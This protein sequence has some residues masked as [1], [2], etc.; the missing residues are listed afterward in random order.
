[1]VFWRSICI[2]FAIICVQVTG[3]VALPQQA[4]AQ[5]HVQP[6]AR[7]LLGVYS[8]KD[9]ASLRDSLIHS[10][11]EMPA[12]HLGFHFRYTDVD[13]SLPALDADVRG[14]VVWLT[15]G[16]TVQDPIALI[17]WLETAMDAGKKII[18]IENFGITDAV[19]ADKQKMAR[20]NRFLYK[21]GMQDVG[22]WSSLTYSSEV[23]YENKEMVGFEL[24]LPKA[25]P[26]Y[27]GTSVV[28]SRATSHLRVR[29][30]VDPE[31][32]SDL[33]ITSPQGGYIAENYALF[34][35]Y[36]LVSMMPEKDKKAAAKTAKKQRNVGESAPSH[37]MNAMPKVVS[38]NAMGKVV[39]APTVQE[40]DGAKALAQTVE[41]P[42]VQQWYINP[43]LFLE[44]ALGS[45]DEPKPD[46]TTLQ[47]K[48]IF[49]S[50]IDGDGWN[51]VSEIER[52]RKNRTLSSEVIYEEILKKYADLPVSVSVIA[53]EM[54][55]ACY[56]RKESADIARNIFALPHVEPASHTYTHPLFW[57]FF[58]D[59]DVAKEVP[60]LHLYPKGTKA[61]RGLYSALTEDEHAA[62]GWEDYFAAH[63]PAKTET[64]EEPVHTHMDY[65]TP[66]SYACA[67]FSVDKEIK[68]AVDV[69]NALAP[70][71]KKVR[72]V[73]WSGDTNPFEA[74]LKATREAGLFNIN[75]G[76][77]RFDFEYPSYTSVSPIG[78]QV[79]DE[80]QIYSSNSNENTYT[81]L[82]TDRFYG[83]RYLRKTAEN[84]ESPRRV[85]PFNIYFH[86]Y[87]GQKQASLNA[88]DENFEFAR[89]Q[90]VI[91][92][93]AADFA[94][95]AQGFYRAKIVQVAPS[96]WRISGR[97]ALQTLRFDHAE[98]RAV[99][100]DASKGVLGYHYFQ[101]ALYVAVQP[102]VDVADIVL[103]Q[104]KT[105][106]YYEKASIPYLVDSNWVIK[107]LT[108]VKKSL[109][110]SAQGYGEMNMRWQMP[111]VGS[112]T[113]TISDSDKKIKEEAIATDAEGMLTIAVK[114][115]SKSSLK[116]QLKQ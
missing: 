6:I 42:L 20:V 43:F 70:A 11:L 79:G 34:E 91:P 88:L 110:F 86:M 67:P 18:L 83:F 51:N 103:K 65:E 112:Y 46:V 116:V 5:E 96:H 45:A 37:A 98:E 26:P 66:R 49:Y 36:P 105:Q 17:D 31:Y 69:V 40:K 24:P 21:L 9:S 82:W 87:S 109:D 16:Q 63:P 114:V 100:M 75:G 80:I 50:H 30:H 72:L 39:T 95:I 55:E 12:N 81:R 90:D 1:M 28:A 8:G 60:L 54:D 13:A 71:G 38:D 25:L 73:Q 111:A 84:T 41:D 74:V 97:G 94:A 76:D 108:V 101:G 44:A 3:A 106:G 107:S 23:I 59:G 32:V 68:G 29:T 2:A 10:Y 104:V 4:Q 7:T 27:L 99:D 92:I 85:Q 93:M 15:A 33:V 22:T 113:L 78:V 89:A 62:T 19:R 57:G 47:G 53:G 58:E 102:E 64:T 115:G 52:Y 35:G 77:S 14:I 61:Q 48:R 56:G